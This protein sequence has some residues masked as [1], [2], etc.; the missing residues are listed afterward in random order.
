MTVNRVQRIGCFLEYALPVAAVL[1]LAVNGILI[2]VNLRNVPELL[3]S[4]GS[5]APSQS[6]ETARSPMPRA[7]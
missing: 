7:V 1:Y 6:T 2:R 3:N 5:A 4:G